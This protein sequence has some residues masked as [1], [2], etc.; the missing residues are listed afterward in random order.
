[1]GTTLEAGSGPSEK[2]PYDTRRN[3]NVR[4]ISRIVFDQKSKIIKTKSI[5]NLNQHHNTRTK[6]TQNS[7]TNDTWYSSKTK[8]LQL[9]TNPTM[10][11]TINKRMPCGGRAYIQHSYT[12]AIIEGKAATVVMQQLMKG[13]SSSN[14]DTI[15]MPKN[16]KA[17]KNGT[18]GKQVKQIKKNKKQNQKKKVLMIKDQ[19]KPTKQA[20]SAKS[21]KS[22][23]VIY[24]D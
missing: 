22:K 5:S 1:V 10:Q 19:A 9:I 7:T 18:S 13:M 2:I 21:K 20:K 24:V 3:P 15:T 8:T 14:F 6:P 17:L 23:S 16:T 12:N 11:Y 4:A